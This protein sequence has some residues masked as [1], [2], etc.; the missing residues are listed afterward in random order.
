MARHLKQS[1]KA[2]ERAETDAGVR[3]QVE[4]ILAR[5]EAEGDAAVR[6]LSTQ[7]DG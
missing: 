2:S 4:D 6:A 3:R 5:I 1:Q 7:F